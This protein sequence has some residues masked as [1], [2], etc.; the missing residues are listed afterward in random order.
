MSLKRLA[1]MAL[2]GGIVVFAWGAVSWMLGW[3]DVAF[4]SFASDD[5]VLETITA[6]APRTGVY[7]A[8]DI[9]T[10]ERDEP[11]LRAGTP[12]VFTSVR[13]DP[14]DGMAPGTY[15]VWLVILLGQALFIA[16][17]M[18]R[19]ALP[20]FGARV[21]FVA[22]AGVFAALTARLPDWYWWGFSGSYTALTM[23]DLAIAWSLAG[24]VMAWLAGRDRRP[25]AEE[26]TQALKRAA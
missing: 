16:T 21:A 20:T 22:G 24:L 25:H 14:R 4:A 10:M 8:P 2:A 19:F 23:L 13:Y 7:L 3:H 17:L 6:Q 26:A 15:I 9:M 1:V 5:A 12:L 18:M 11:P